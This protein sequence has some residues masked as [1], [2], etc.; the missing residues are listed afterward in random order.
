[1]IITKE[2]YD[3]CDS[4]YQ[5]VIDQLEKEI[6]DIISRNGDDETAAACQVCE[7][8]IEFSKKYLTPYQ[9]WQL[10]IR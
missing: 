3:K 9:Y 1:M 6:D 4:T 7:C 5:K 2:F 8:I 10:Y